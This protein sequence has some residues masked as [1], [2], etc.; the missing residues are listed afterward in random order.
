MP[1]GNLNLQTLKPS[2]LCWHQGC[3][4]A[5]CSIV[6]NQNEIPIEMQAHHFTHSF[7]SG[8]KLHINEYL[9]ISSL[10]SSNG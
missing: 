5:Y 6:G 7:H 9:L 8:F 2:L 10:I 4:I 1:V 3:N